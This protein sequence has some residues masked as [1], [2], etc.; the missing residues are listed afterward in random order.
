MK[1]IVIDCNGITE[2]EG[3]HRLF[4]DTLSLPEWCADNLDALYDCLTDLEEPTHVILRNFAG[5]NIFREMLLDAAD[6]DLGFSITI[7]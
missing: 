7:V 5:P 2:K 3:L 6:A 4:A 1:E